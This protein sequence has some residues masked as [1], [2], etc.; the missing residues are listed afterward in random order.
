MTSINSSGRLEVGGG[1]QIYWEDWGSPEGSPILSF[2]G[3]PGSCF[4]DKHKAHFDPKI[5]RVIFFDQRGCG[6][7][8][9]FA[10]TD[11]NTTQDTIDDAEK[12]REMLGINRWHVVGGSW[13]SALSLMYAVAH[14]DRVKSMMIWGVYTMRQFEDDW[15]NEGYP[16]H[17]FPNEWARFISFVP[18][19]KRVN[20]LSIMEYYA[21]EMRSSD[22]DRAK[23]YAFEWTLWESVLLSIEYDPD[24]VESEVE[25]DP[26]TL[27]IALLETHYFLNNCFVEPDHIYK[28]IEKIRSIPCYAVQGRFDMCTPPETAQILGDAYGD[29]YELSYVNS[30]HLRSDIELK[31]KLTELA[32]LKL[33]R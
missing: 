23:K 21:E 16:R 2:H 20:G 4:S 6:K 29:M 7:S 19:E 25:G 15:V 8:L 30:G 12:L 33:V 27:P 3:G 18:E 31:L 5:H 9:P 13:G 17:F 28:N 24:H 10:S 32:K 26:S 14:P 11:N 22:G 1:H